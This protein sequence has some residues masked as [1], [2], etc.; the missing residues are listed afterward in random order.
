MS[1]G[2]CR[3]AAVIRRD[4]ANSRSRHAGD[5]TAHPAAQAN[6]LIDLTIGAHGRRTRADSTTIREP[7]KA[8][9]LGI[10]AIPLFEVADS[11]LVA[12]TS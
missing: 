1:P 11:V 9:G 2:V 5:R 7:L 3:R 12:K 4:G 6:Q 8:A 10:E